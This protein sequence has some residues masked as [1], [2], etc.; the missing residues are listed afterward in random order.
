MFDIGFQELVIIFIVALLVIGP[1]K[2]P[3]FSRNLGKW[4]MEIRRGIH[5]AKSRIEDEINTI[6]IPETTA[7]ACQEDDK[8]YGVM[9]EQKATEEKTTLAEVIDN[10]VPD[11]ALSS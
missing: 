8:S 11:S 9:S 4:I 5:I 2:L 3:E 7:Q 6:K 10:N 1:K